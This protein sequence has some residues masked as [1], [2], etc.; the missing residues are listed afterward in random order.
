MSHTSPGGEA[1][2]AAAE[3]TSPP[4]R[5]VWGVLA[6]LVAASLITG[7]VLLSQRGDEGATAASSPTPATSTAPSPTSATPTPA[8]ATTLALIADFGNCGP[9]AQRVADMIDTWDAAAVTTAGDN[10]YNDDPTCT[11][12]TDSVGDFYGDWVEDPEGPRFWPALGNHDYEDKGAGLEKYRAYF[13]YLPTEADPQQRWYDVKVD[14]IHLFILDNDAPDA[15]LAAQQVWLRERLTAS[16]AQDPAAWNVVIFHKPA[17]TSASHP[18]EVE[19]R[20]DAGWDYRGWGAD[21]VIAGHQH[22][23]E[24]VVV[25]GMHYVTAGIATNGLERGGCDDELTDG[26][27]LCLTGVEGAMRLDATATSLRMEYRQPSDAGE[28]V[29]DAIELTR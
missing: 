28:V 14:G 18:D 6:A 27:R 16:R 11:P 7:W 20:P 8:A 17:F 10:T 21:V 24:D 1:R 13:T 12:F 23:Y 19:M 3:S 22:A 4:R 9:G 25:D 2:P 5:W 29:L 15:D 26:S